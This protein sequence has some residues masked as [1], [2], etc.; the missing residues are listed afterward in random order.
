MI[1]ELLSDL[2]REEILLL[3][4]RRNG[5]CTAYALTVTTMY[6]ERRAEPTPTERKVLE[7]AADY[8]AELRQRRGAA[9]RRYADEELRGHVKQRR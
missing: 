9:R 2:K 6:C 1:P 5:I 3:M 7:A 8:V 4:R